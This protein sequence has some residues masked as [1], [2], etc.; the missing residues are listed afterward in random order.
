MSSFE[1]FFLL[2][3]F[4][5]VSYE[6]NW[7]QF[8]F[9]LLRTV[10]LKL[11]FPS[12]QGIFRILCEN[13]SSVDSCRWVSLCRDCSSC[14][15]LLPFISNKFWNAILRIRFIRKLEKQFIYY[16]YCVVSILILCFLDSIREM[17]KYSSREDV[18]KEVKTVNN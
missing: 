18:A 5:H 12:Q 7:K 17:T 14:S 4:W 11:T 9:P 3:T 13:E 6:I 2:L 16:F 15:I 10:H 8:S 1:Q